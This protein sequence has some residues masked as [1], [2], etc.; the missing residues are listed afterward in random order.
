MF[1]LDFKVFKDIVVE[2]NRLDFNK[3]SKCKNLDD[4]FNR[5]IHLIKDES[6]SPNLMYGEKTPENIDYINNILKYNPKMKF[7]ILQ[8]NFYDII[9]SLEN[10]GWEGF[11]NRLNYLRRCIESQENLKELLLNNTIIIN[12]E[13]NIR[14]YRIIKKIL[15]FLN[16]G[17]IKKSQIENALNFKSHINI[18]KKE[19]DIH[20]SLVAGK[21]KNTKRKFK[22]SKTEE[23]LIDELLIKK[24]K[25]YLSEIILIKLGLIL[26]KLFNNK[27][28]LVF[29]KIRK[30]IIKRQNK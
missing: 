24:R 27:V 20:S 13:Y 25:F 3:F 5:Y 10:R 29:K 6:K 28:F 26:K 2:K 22:L 1:E 7:I 4:F 19:L 8:R 23:N 21:I 12:Y 14:S 18:E 11:L 16:V 15:G 17:K 30:N 9:L